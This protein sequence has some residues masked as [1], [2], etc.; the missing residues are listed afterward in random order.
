MLLHVCISH[1]LVGVFT[2]RWILNGHLTVSTPH[3]VWLYFSI[4][5]GFCLGLFI[6]CS[7]LLCHVMCTLDDKAEI[8]ML[9][10]IAFLVSLIWLIVSS[11]LWFVWKN[12]LWFSS[13]FFYY[14]RQFSFVFLDCKNWAKRRELKKLSVVIW[15]RLFKYGSANFLTINSPC[16]SSV[17]LRKGSVLPQ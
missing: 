14:Y 6:L 13:C 15:Y 17:L 4:V 1:L 8:S 10:K 5:L 12:C 16:K 11:T 3:F 9:I 7:S 2:R